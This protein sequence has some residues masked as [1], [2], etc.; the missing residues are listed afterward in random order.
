[1]TY[2]EHGDPDGS[3]AIKPNQRLNPKVWEKIGHH[4]SIACTAF[5][6]TSDSTTGDE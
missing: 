5:S 1:M 2:K 6:Q 4:I 3:T